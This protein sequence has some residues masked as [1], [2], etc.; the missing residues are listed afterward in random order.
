MIAIFSAPSFAA[1]SFFPAQARYLINFARR[2]SEL[3]D[4]ATAS[5]RASEKPA[6]LFRKRPNETA[7]NDPS[8]LLDSYAR[9]LIFPPPPKEIDYEVHRQVGYPQSLCCFR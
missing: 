1:E 4:T 6:A 2:G 3:R 7:A 8:L 5:Q 9:T